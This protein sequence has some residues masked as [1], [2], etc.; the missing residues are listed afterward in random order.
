MGYRL[1]GYSGFHKEG[2]VVKIYARWYKR[3][4][5]E[6]NEEFEI[7]MILDGYEIEEEPGE[8]LAEWRW[9]VLV[10]GK[11]RTVRDNQV[12]ILKEEK[13]K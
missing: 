6:E 1:Y 10:D 7:G 5:N 8:R 13:R 4:D 9:R 12:R 3:T 11:L 2:D